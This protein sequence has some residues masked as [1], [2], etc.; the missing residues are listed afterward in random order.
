MA[1]ARWR[2]EL[3]AVDHTVEIDFDRRAD[4]LIGL[5]P[6]EF[7]EGHAEFAMRLGSGSFDVSQSLIWS[8]QRIKCCP[9]RLFC[10]A[11]AAMRTEAGLVELVDEKGLPYLVFDPAGQFDSYYTT[12]EVDDGG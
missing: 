7:G 5:E 9:A 10:F 6:P 8:E 2:Q 11:K 4:G 12:V 1:H 3:A